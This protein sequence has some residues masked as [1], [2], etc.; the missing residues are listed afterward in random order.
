MAAT[1]KTLTLKMKAE[2]TSTHNDGSNNSADDNQGFAGSQ[3]MLGPSG[4]ARRPPVDHWC[5]ESLFAHEAPLTY[6]QTVQEQKLAK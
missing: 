1:T 4:R 2:T 5:P 3:D 6:T